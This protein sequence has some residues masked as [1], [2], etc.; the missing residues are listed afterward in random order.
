MD[1]IWRICF[2][3]SEDCL[4]GRKSDDHFFWVTQDVTYDYRAKS[5]SV[6][7]LHYVELL[8]K[9]DAELRRKRPHLAKKKVLCH[10]ENA[11]AYISSAATAK[12]VGL[13]YELLPHPSYCPKFS[14]LFYRLSN[15][16]TTLVSTAVCRGRT[17]SGMKCRKCR[18]RFNAATATAA[19]YTALAT[20]SP[21]KFSKNNVKI[22]EASLPSCSAMLQRCHMASFATFCVVFCFQLYY[23]FY[24][25][26]RICFVKRFLV[27]HIF[28]FYFCVFFFA[29]FYACNIVVNVLIFALIYLASIV[30]HFGAFA[31]RCSVC[32]FCVVHFVF[33]LAVL[34]WFSASFNCVF[35]NQYDFNSF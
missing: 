16:R 2:E 14:F 33:A 6:T 9:F 26:F 15:H 28:C 23:C 35:W 13:A 20:M 24:F 31:V 27:A 7:R 17:T 8:G 5:K 10:H 12:L 4:I 11:S 30:F 19:G 21:M 29:S 22:V 32:V 18:E 1:F 34:P 3:E 25:S